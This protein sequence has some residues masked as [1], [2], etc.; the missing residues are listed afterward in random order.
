[1]QRCRL[2][3][4]DIRRR[5]S[6]AREG[7]YSHGDLAVRT[8]G[9]ID[10]PAFF[11]ALDRETGTN[12]PLSASAGFVSR[13]QHPGD[14]SP[15]VVHPLGK[16]SVASGDLVV[17]ANWHTVL[18]RPHD[19]VRY[20]T[21]LKGKIP[22]DTAWYAPASALPSTVALLAYAGFDI[23]DF[24]A[25]DLETARGS[26]CLA[27]GI[28]PGDFA[29][30]EACTCEGCACGDIGRH[31][32]LA[33]ERELALIRRFIAESRL[34]DLVE[35]RCRAD[36]HQVAIMRLLDGE[37][38]LLEPYTPV[39]RPTPFIATTSESLRRIEVKRWGRRL[40]ERSASPIH[41]VAVLLPCSARK[42]YSTSLSHHRFT[43]AV[44]GRAHELIVTSPLGLV[45][46]E[47][48]RVYPAAH[49]DI[50]VTG[51]WDREELALISSVI[52]GYLGR[53]PYRRV[54]A[55]LEGG[56]L[57]AARMAADTCGIPL[58]VTAEG[59]PTEPASL[60]ALDGALEGER[61]RPAEGVRGVLAWQFGAT[62][63]TRGMAIRGRPPQERVEKGGRTLFTIDARTGFLRPTFEGWALI[64]EGYR[65]RI[66]AFTP[67][68]DILAPGITS[69][70]EGIREGDEVLVLGEGLFATGRAAMGGPE[71]LRSRH[72]VAVRVRRIKRE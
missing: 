63:E 64:P 28:F 45:P 21:T 46:R 49:Y 6:L 65:V 15:V 50:P 32:R 33:L 70:D 30:A 37:E 55:H 23:F 27:E 31:N 26:F 66:D 17:V 62:V 1:V 9:I 48:E 34:R 60:T 42:P 16:E 25:V 12:V 18:S 51:H 47:L 11:P 43:R 2:S 7:I 59:H 44:R 4:F 52:A 24:R 54:L 36:P 69:A 39:T 10:I 20:L 61:R 5:D 53:H 41:E 57:D 22:P 3:L 71:M 58:E 38:A 14:G 68:G 40:V 67:K 35:A 8:P 13:Y 72:G 56:A 19:F 29:G